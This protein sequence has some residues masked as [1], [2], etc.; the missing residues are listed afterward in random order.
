MTP[1]WSA[2]RVAS[3]YALLGVV[4]AIVTDRVMLAFSPDPLIYSQVG[5]WREVVFI[6]ATA[7]FLFLLTGKQST[8]SKELPAFDLNRTG[9]GPLIMVFAALATAIVLLGLGG[10]AYTAGKQKEKEVERLLAIADLKA[11]QIVAWIEERQA[12]AQIIRGDDYLAELY[13]HWRMN[14]NAVSRKKLMERLAVHRD[15]YNYLDILLLDES[16]SVLMATGKTPGSLPAALQEAARRAIETG[17]LH[18]TDLYRPEGNTPAMVHLDFV[19][20][21]PTKAGRPRLA[22]ALRTD[23]NRFLFPFIQ[24]WPIPSA[25]AETLLFRRDGDHALFLNELRHRTDTALNL[26]VPFSEANLLAVQVLQ[27]RA[28]PGQAV[29]GVD[30]RNVPVLGVVKAI[31]GTSWFLI[32]KLDKSELYA[33]A[34][35]D[36]GW[37]ALAEILALVAAAAAT[38]LLYQRRELRFSQIQREQQADKLRAF[39]LLDAIAEGSTDAI[40]A[41]DAAGRYLLLNRELSRFAGKTRAEI[42]GQDDTAIF[43]PAEAARL[44]AGDRRVLDAGRIEASE[45]MLS[46]IGGVRIFLVTRGPLQDAEGKT[47]GLFGIARDITEHKYQ[48][49]ELQTSEARFR[50]IFDGVNEAIFLHDAES[51]AIIDANTRMTEMFGYSRKEARRLSM[52]DLSADISPHA[53]EEARQCMG[54]AQ[55]GENPVFEWLARRRDGSQFWVEASLRRAEI[56]GRACI[57]ELVRD[58]TER[59]R[60]AEEIRRLNET[61]ERRMTERD[62]GTPDD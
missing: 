50:A 62:P 52:G 17:R 1:N 39:Q 5:I 28:S 25:S 29:E 44:M 34:K 20:P 36:A 7:F 33:Q 19:V 2:L 13:E 57:L 59:K 37:I 18:S 31:P 23:T 51:G 4:W 9:I 41:K 40:Y 49:R 27:G 24:S 45:E 8:E 38:I 12:D 15:A 48:E 22:V 42:L 61:L 14:E 47:I 11:G 26:R 58:I 21:L 32:A 53:R 30:Y 55:R 10:V 35:R 6:L 46:T 60:A 16:G 43:P 56:G 54:Q 3:A